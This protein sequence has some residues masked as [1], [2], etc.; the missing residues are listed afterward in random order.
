MDI[1]RYKE[2]KELTEAAYLVFKKLPTQENASRYSSLKL[3]LQEL[4]VEIVEDMMKE[5]FPEE[6]KKE[7][8]LENIE[9][10]RYCKTCDSEILYQIS[11]EEFI[12]SSDFVEGF[13]G[14]CY[15]CLL[16]HCSKTNCDECTVSEDPTSC[17]FR[18][19]KEITNSVVN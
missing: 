6:D 11:P 2:L 19:V 16:T 7:P 5:Q 9:K 17:S 3:Q 18:S 4:C 12:A 8:I 15:D 1:S 13:P 14:W 10:Y